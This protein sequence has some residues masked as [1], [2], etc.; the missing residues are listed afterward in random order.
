MPLFRGIPALSPSAFRAFRVALSVMLGVL[1]VSIWEGDIPLD[2]QREA[3]IAVIPGLRLLAA[4]PA[5][6]AWLQRS[7]LAALVLFGAGLWPRAA[8]AAVALGFNLWACLLSLRGG[9]HFLGP[10]PL[11]L[12]FLLPVPWQF[13]ARTGPASGS[14]GRMLVPPGYAPWVLSL[15]FS[16]AF[17]A[18]GYAK[19]AQWAMNGSVRYHFMVEADIAWVSFGPWIA[20]HTGLSVLLSWIVVV[21]EHAAIVAPFLVPRWRAVAGVMAAGLLVGFTVMHNALWPAWWTL[22]L[23]FAPWHL[24]ARSGE[25]PV[26]SWP[27]PALAVVAVAVL[28]TQQ[29]VATARRIEAGPYLSAYDM[30]STTWDSPDVFVRANGQPEFRVVA[31]T[32]GGDVDVGGCVGADAASRAELEA[33]VSEEPG[34][35]SALARVQA[36]AVAC[37]RQVSGTRVRVAAEQ[38]FFDWQHGATGWKFKGVVGDWPVAPAPS[39]SEV[40]AG[41]PRLHA[42]Q[43]VP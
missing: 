3:P 12:V 16:I 19:G 17:A 1:L 18:A 39:R 10:L 41:E 23:G 15:A 21:L 24:I 33:S 14:P 30:Y 6:M 5:A 32:P 29:L 22:L 36:R 25:T 20:A 4:Q 31:T 13:G 28:A 42:V 7:L 2:V 26:P 9:I 43:H 37:A 35:A 40:V 11:A 38:R 27:R 8:F 34:R